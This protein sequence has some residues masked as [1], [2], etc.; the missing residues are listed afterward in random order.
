MDFEPLTAIDVGST[1]FV[2]V[3][4]LNL[5]DLQTCESFVHHFYRR[6]VQ[7]KPLMLQARNEGG[8]GSD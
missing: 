5:I 3:I 2:A 1:P 8:G 6:K 4:F 7:N